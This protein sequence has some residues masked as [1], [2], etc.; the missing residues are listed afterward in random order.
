MPGL[1]VLTVAPETKFVPVSVTLVLL[2]AVPLAG[3]IELNVGVLGAA[4]TI[5]I[6]QIFAAW[7][8]GVN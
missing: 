1:A 3:E 8:K 2:P 6:A 4:L 7:T 5:S